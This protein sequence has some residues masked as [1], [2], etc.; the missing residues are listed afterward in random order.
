MGFFVLLDSI[1]KNKTAL[2]YLILDTNIWIYLA[3]SYNPKN[4]NYED[5][6]HFKLV[7]S[8]KK[9]IDSGDIIN[10]TNEIIIEEWQRNKENAKKL[11]EKHKKTFQGNKGSVKNIKKYL[12]SDDKNNLEEIFN[13]YSENIQKVIQD[14]ERHINEVE[15]LLINKST[16]IEIPDKVKVIAAERAIK[17]LAPFKGDKSNS[18]ADAVIL[19]G[20]IKYLKEISRRPSWEEGEDNFFIFPESIFVTNNKGDFA[21]PDNESEAHEELKPLFDEVQMKYEMNIGKI[22][23]KAHADLIAYEEIQQIERDLEEA[24][25]WKNVIH[26]EVCY[27]D[28]EKMYVNN[29]VEFGEPV[30]IENEMNEKDNPDQLKLFTIE[31][32]DKKR[33][34]E[35]IKQSDINTVQLGSCTYC[36]SEYIKC[37]CCGTA[38]NYGDF[39]EGNRLECEGCGM[40]Y[41]IDY[42]YIGSGMHEEE[43]KI[44]PDRNEEEE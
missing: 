40:I 20:S 2:T 31:P 15:E 9:L 39:L 21:N 24:E 23:N 25:Y 11:I 6:L 34:E 32:I 33:E 4:E 17:K 10:L 19:L 28:P 1:K 26:C 12:E 5:G 35:K 16:K 30:E 37:Q 14:N 8:L 3:N 7:E 18:M 13:K 29:V 42:H 44:V 22:I 41:Q 43:I 27:P 38:N 36:S